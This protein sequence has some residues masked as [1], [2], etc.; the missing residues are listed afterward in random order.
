MPSAVIGLKFVLDH[1]SLRHPSAIP[2]LSKPLKGPSPNHLTTVCLRQ[3]PLAL[4]ISAVSFQL[5]PGLQNGSLRAVGARQVPVT[6]RGFGIGGGSCH[7]LR[8][9]RLLTEELGFLDHHW[10]AADS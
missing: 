9:V 4:G 10:S 5:F 7:A 8:L 3:L 1:L 6:L 2:S